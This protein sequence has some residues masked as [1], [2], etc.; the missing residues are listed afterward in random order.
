[1]A[2]PGPPIDNCNSG[3]MNSRVSLNKPAQFVLESLQSG[4]ILFNSSS[5][6]NI[7]LS[8]KSLVSHDKI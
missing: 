5:S 7:V 3:L 6:F 2:S 8:N 4:I 1:M